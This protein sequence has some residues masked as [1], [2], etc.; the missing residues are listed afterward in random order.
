MRKTIQNGRR[1]GLASPKSSKRNRARNNANNPM[2]GIQRVHQELAVH[3]NVTRGGGGKKAGGVCGPRICPG[4][5]GG[6]AHV[7]SPPETTHQRPFPSRST[8]DPTCVRGTGCS[9]L[10]IPFQEDLGDIQALVPVA[11]DHAGDNQLRQVLDEPLRRAQVDWARKQHAP[12]LR[13]A[14]GVEPC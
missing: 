2:M 12:L 14:H 1:P 4:G 5:A 11:L 6:R 8:E 3:T 13:R 7:V 10:R 9:P